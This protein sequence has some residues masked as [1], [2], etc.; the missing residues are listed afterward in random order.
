MEQKET[1]AMAT[2]LREF[3][4]KGLGEDDRKFNILYAME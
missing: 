3:Q 4:V 2:S 1:S